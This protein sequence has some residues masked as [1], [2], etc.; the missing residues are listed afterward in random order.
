MVPA[1]VD[2]DCG[3]K[4]FRNYSIVPPPPPCMTLK[5]SQNAKLPT[6]RATY[7]SHTHT[8]TSDMIC[9]CLAG[10]SKRE[11][12]EGGGGKRLED[13]WK[14]IFLARCMWRRACGG[15]II[16]ETAGCF[17]YLCR[18]R[19]DEYMFPFFY[20]PIYDPVLVT[21]KENR[22]WLLTASNLYLILV[23]PVLLL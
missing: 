5:N 17:C 20:V 23:S 8:H 9:T 14:S 16:P 13:Q 19:V 6:R 10:R 21:I 15:F 3:T 4:N 7:F 1:V 12:E 11:E 22:G 18:W 2:V